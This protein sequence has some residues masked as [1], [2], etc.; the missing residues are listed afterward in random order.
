[1]S[2]RSEAMQ[3]I[4]YN[5]DIDFGRRSNANES[6]LL[7]QSIC[8]Q[9]WQDIFDTSMYAEMWL[10]ERN[11]A[12]F[13]LGLEDL[14][15]SAQN[16]CTWCRLLKKHVDDMVK[17]RGVIN[18]GAC[19][20]VTMNVQRCHDSRITPAGSFD[21]EVAIEIPYSSRA[22]RLGPSPY[23]QDK[24]W[25][26]GST[27]GSLH[28]QL[29]F[30]VFAHSSDPAAKII[31]TRDLQPVVHSP[32]A[33]T[34]VKR[35]IE[36]C[37]D[38][39]GCSTTS[40]VLLPTRVI[41]VLPISG[42]Q[43]SRLL[44][45]NGRKGRYN[46]LSYCWGSQ[47]TVLTHQNLAQFQIEID[48]SMLSKTVQD[49]I[50]ITISLGIPYLWIDAICI[51]QD[52]P[53]DKALEISRMAAIYQSSHIT[54]VAASAK[55]ADEGFLLP[56]K[57]PSPATTIAFMHNGFHAGTVNIRRRLKNRESPWGTDPWP[58]SDPVDSRAWTLQE[59]LLSERLLVYSTDTLQWRC[60]GVVANLGSSKYEP[61]P[62]ESWWS[63]SSVDFVRPDPVPLLLNRGTP[64]VY[65]GIEDLVHD[66]VEDIVI[67][68]RP[69]ANPLGQQ[70]AE[71]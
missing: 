38:H 25:D 3:E 49:A 26:V 21:L 60:K 34:E 64:D 7:R 63:T 55:H 44:V 56:R 58:S 39:V 48:L 69:S 71:Q 40:D 35:W 33:I 10:D 12:V 23:A 62:D 51:L 45:T 30:D 43:R 14:G 9:C 16:G 15:T 37:A 46:T 5:L 36:S 29:T 53:Q 6:S 65:S 17:S 28:R 19:L 47:S 13:A 22:V 42:K 70:A 2:K 41:E 68:R 61:Q 27:S 31:P 24:Y 57:A 67:S 59:Q 8:K 11:R 32:E 52:S 4:P 20:L 1:M 50:E 54:I 18:T 66:E